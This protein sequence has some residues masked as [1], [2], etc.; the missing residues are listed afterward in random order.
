MI[1]SLNITKSIGLLSS[2]FPK[3]NCILKTMHTTLNLKHFPLLKKIMRMSDILLLNVKLLLSWY[4]ENTSTIRLKCNKLFTRNLSKKLNNFANKREVKHI[5]SSLEF[6]L[7][8]H[9][10]NL[11]RH[12]LH[13][14]FI[15]I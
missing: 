15:N 14:P 5:P 7:L 12:H 11:N 3:N 4:N 10:L 13:L 9:F 1:V 2:R 6:S 8:I